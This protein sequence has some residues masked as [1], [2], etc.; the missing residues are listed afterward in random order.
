MRFGNQNRVCPSG[1]QVLEGL[2][3]GWKT[4]KSGCSVLIPCPHCTPAPLYPQR[5]CDRCEGVWAQGPLWPLGCT[6]SNIAFQPLSKAV[7]LAGHCLAPHI[8]VQGPGLMLG[9]KGRRSLWWL[10]WSVEAAAKPQAF[11]KDLSSLGCFHYTDASRPWSWG[12]PG[13]WVQLVNELHP[14]TP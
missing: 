13:L 14:S 9:L 10:P 5:A 8:H 11:R 12:L 2:L 3:L 1:G 4:R 6:R 7:F